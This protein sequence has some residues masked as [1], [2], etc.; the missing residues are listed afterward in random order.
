[1]TGGFNCYDHSSYRH[2]IPEVR[3]CWLSRGKYDQLMGGG[4]THC[5]MGSYR[6]NKLPVAYLLSKGLE[7]SIVLN[8]SVTNIYIY[9]YRFLLQSLH[10][11]VALIR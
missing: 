7:V 5:L 4:R 11:H 10:A 6:T 1:M 9:I 3:G 2:S 8:L